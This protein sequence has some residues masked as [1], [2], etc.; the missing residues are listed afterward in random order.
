MTVPLGEDVECTATNQ[1][2]DMSVTKQVQGGDAQPSDFTFRLTPLDPVPPAGT[3]TT[4]VAGSRRTSARS[5][6]TRP[7]R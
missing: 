1:T 5:R 3:R 4:C 2:A 7:K 6:T